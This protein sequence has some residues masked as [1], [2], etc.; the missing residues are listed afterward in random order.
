MKNK[1]IFTEGSIPKKLIAF[2]LPVLGA[3]VLQAM[4]GAVDLLIVG[5]FGTP[6]GISAVST[7]SNIINL[8]TFTIAG[9]TMG[10][11]VIIGQYIGEKKADRIGK[12]IGGALS[13]FILLTVIFTAF[14]VLGAD[15]LTSLMRAPKEA[16]ALTAQYVM[17]CGGGLIFIFAYN[18]IS[19]IF[20]G[21]GNSRLPLLFVAIACVVNIIGDL[22]FVAVLDMNVAGAALATVGAQT[23]SVILS[24]II[25]KRQ[26]LP[27]K[28]SLKDIRFCEETKKVLRVGL[29]IS[30]QDI[31]TNV[32]FLVICA[33]INNISL[34][35]SS[36]YG[37][38]QKVISFIMLIP[39][40]LMQSMSAFISQN[41]GAKQ[42]KR[43]K[44]SM[45]CGMG[46]GASVGVVIFV[47]IFFFGSLP[48][49]LFS[50]NAEY[51]AESAAYLRGFA[52]DTVITC[53]L[54]SFM[55][56]FNGS[57]RTLFVMIQGITSAF[58]IRIPASYLMS[59]GDN[60]SLA[61]IGFAVPISTVFGIIVCSIYYIY[62]NKKQMLS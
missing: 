28:F 5:K 61:K 16:H 35:A 45:Y 31:L 49:S 38:A 57:G 10:M 24:L 7:G 39:S 6:E 59:L 43:A 15:M 40:S 14:V 25:I 46:M 47:L 60:P 50:D 19:G 29:P 41:I 33:L 36:G 34:A 53:V 51:I 1:D 17:I 30:L 37:I 9:L 58:L 21:M 32:S 12:I 56:Y 62:L 44:K 27:F 11:T 20:R 26:K 22:L 54:F 23:V 2:M 18:I 52:I 42:Y 3:L 8:F 13:V 48:S 4:Y 55:G